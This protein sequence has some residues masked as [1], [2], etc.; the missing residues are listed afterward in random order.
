[1]RTVRQIEELLAELDHCIAQDLEDQ[2]LDFKQWN[3][4]SIDDSVNLIV[5]MAVC[6][7]NGGGGTVV[8]GV[9]E[10]ALGRLNAIRGVPAEIDINRL[11]KAVYDKTDPKIT[12]VFEELRVSEGT[13]RLLVMQIYPG[14]P[15]YTDTAGRGTIRIGKDCQPLT[16]TLRRRIAVETGETD[17][18]A[19]PLDEICLQ[20]FLLPLWRCSVILHGPKRP[21]KAFF[22]SPIVN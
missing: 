6:M 9:A 5:K 4:R 14:M 13:G 18:T 1:M 15:P 22:I 7:A 12:P 2:D 3:D 20:C 16:G 17:F 10:N 21:L 11:K 8:M 19:E